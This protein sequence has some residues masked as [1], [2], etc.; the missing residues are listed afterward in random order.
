MMYLHFTLANSKDE[1]QGHAN[2]D[3]EYLVNRDIWDKY[4]YSQ[5]IGSRL[6]TFRL[7]YLYLTLITYKGQSECRA[8]IGCEYI[9]NGDIYDKYSAP[10]SPWTYWHHINIDYISVYLILLSQMHRK[11]YIDFRLMYLHLTL[12]QA[13]GQSQGHA[14]FDCEYLVKGDR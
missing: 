11:S 3:C 13:K 10:L 4:C 12:T 9:V 1:M 5:C 2:C 8:N 14:H 6:L 7:V